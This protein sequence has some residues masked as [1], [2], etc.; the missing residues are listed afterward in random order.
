MQPKRH[1]D[2]SRSYER[3]VNITV[4]LFGKAMSH[5]PII[6]IPPLFEGFTNFSRPY[7]L[8]NRELDF[9]MIYYTFYKLWKDT[10]ESDNCFVIVQ[11]R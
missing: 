3:A 10:P 7:A 9:R 11:E 4:D 5:H 2:V 8:S 6:E 1:K